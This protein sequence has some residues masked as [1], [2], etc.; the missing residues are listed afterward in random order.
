MHRLSLVRQKLNKG[1][2]L[3]AWIAS[4]DEVQAQLFLQD[5]KRF[6][7]ILNVAASDLGQNVID[8]DGHTAYSLR[9]ANGL[10]IHSMSSNVDAQA[11]KRGDRVLDEFALHPDPRKLYTIAY[12]GV[13]WGGSLEIFQH[14]GTQNYFCELL[15]EITER[16]NPKGSHCTIHLKDAPEG[17]LY[18]LQCKL[19]D[20]PRIKWTRPITSVS[21]G[22]AQD[23]E[24]SNIQP[25]D[26]NTPSCH[27]TNLRLRIRE[28]KN[29][30]IC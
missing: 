3:D 7:D 28:T 11:G 14:R 13:T 1:A 16:G 21:S 29:Q 26:D 2:R 4:R 24:A 6:A 27:T 10:R 17:F 25:D 5:A 19:P 23:E 8:D 20:D 18:T 30:R 9:F 15:R 22:R 12:P